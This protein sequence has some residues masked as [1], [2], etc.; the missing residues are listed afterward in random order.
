MTL[1]RRD[2]LL[3]GGSLALA[4]SASDL[5]FGATILAVRVWPAAEYTRVTIESDQ[6]LIAHNFMAESSSDM[7]SS[8][9]WTTPMQNSAIMAM[10]FLLVI[11]S[12]IGLGN[13]GRAALPAAYRRSQARGL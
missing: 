3:R 9:A 8:C 10:A 11:I 12:F 6:P 4:L 1:K 13:I 2:V 7:I 5:A